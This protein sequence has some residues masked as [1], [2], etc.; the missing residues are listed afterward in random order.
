[1]EDLNSKNKNIKGGVIPLIYVKILFKINSFNYIIIIFKI[2]L[3]NFQ[4]GNTSILQE[5]LR[6]LKNLNISLNFIFTDKI[7]RIICFRLV[8][9]KIRFSNFI[10]QPNHRRRQDT[11]V[12][13]LVNDDV[14]VTIFCIPISNRK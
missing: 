6:I 10:V 8:G 3:K 7:I 13:F 4:S 5:Y 11:R 9:H 1:M 14:Y 2:I 12:S